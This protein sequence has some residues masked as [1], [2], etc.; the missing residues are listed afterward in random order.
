MSRPTPLCQLDGL[1]TPVLRG[2]G[3]GM[4]ISF[5][6]ATGCIYHICFTDLTTPLY[7]YL[8]LFLSLFAAMEVLGERD[9]QSRAVGPAMSMSP[10][11]SDETNSGGTGLQAQHLRSAPLKRFHSFSIRCPQHFPTSFCP[12]SAIPHSTAPPHPPLFIY[13]TRLDSDCSYL[14]MC[15]EKDTDACSA[16][17]K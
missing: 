3:E 14:F 1:L 17:A 9:N 7:I 12:F 16:K 6:T 5:P 10:P 13:S 2:R 15:L 11:P 4:F 8:S